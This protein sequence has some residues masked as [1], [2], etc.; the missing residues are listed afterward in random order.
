MERAMG[1]DLS[2]FSMQELFRL[3]AEGTTQSMTA[4]LLT[5][6]REPARQD[7]LEDCMRAAHSLKGAGRIV[8]LL[9]AVTIAH[10]ME[11]L[12]VL[13][14]K[15]QVA[16]DQP[17]IDQLLGGIDLIQALACAP[18]G[19]S[20]SEEAA[21]AADAERFAGDLARG[22]VAGG[23]PARRDAPEIHPE[24]RPEPHPETRPE[25]APL[26]AQDGGDASLRVSADTLNRMLDLA[27]ETLVESH[28]LRPFEEALLRIKRLQRAAA[29]SLEALE[30]ALPP[31]LDERARLALSQAREQVFACRQQLAQQ[32][33]SLETQNHRAG[34]LA[35]RLYNQALTVRMRPFADGLGA[36]PRMVRDIARDLGKQVAFD[37]T[38]ERTQIDRDILEKL[39]APLMHLLRNALDHGLESPEERLAAGKDAQGVIRLS[40][41]HHAGALQI[42][43]ADD[44][45]GIDPEVIRA[46]VVARGLS[47]PDTAERL[48]ESELFEFLFLP[49]FSMKDTVTHLSGRGVG[50]DVVQD[51][52]RQVRGLVRVTSRAGEGTQFKL[53][54][55]LTL[56][57]V[58]ALLVEI[59]GEPY[60]FPFAHIARAVRVPMEE[61]HR[62]EGRQYIT[63]DGQNIGLVGAD[64][65]FGCAPPPAGEG[66]SVVLLGGAAGL[67][68][69]V[70]DGFS[71]GAELVVRPLDPRL[72]KIRDI[73]AAALTEDGA[74]L[75]IVDVDDMVRSLEKLSAS[76]RLGPVGQEGARGPAQRR[77]RVLV[78]DDSFTVRELERKL[79]D[80]HGY[81]V[82]VA[83][84]G[85]DGWNALRE[86]PFDL[87]ISDIDMPRMDGIELVR[88]IRADPGLKAMPVMIL[89]YKDR[90]ED[91]QRG[92]EVGA[93]YYLTKG[94]FQN[95]ALIEAV[96]DLIGEPVS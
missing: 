90:E 88:R 73:A 5:L 63:V 70:V 83:V 16:L 1:Q 92:L 74:P 55:P 7:L 8:G 66:L 94:S 80:S 54:L 35:H 68:G 53:E 43:V 42:V 61:V 64:Q 24:T 76:D 67:H 44:G 40:A 71:G 12:F 45:R 82:E 9:P 10:A 36:L 86:R 6:E 50:L 19:Q 15:G 48:S 28:R 25:P 18:E 4:A 49:G 91:R 13:A 2:G 11:D 56:S 58:R 59:G 89:S 60:A 37:I 22:P 72:G 32:L 34:N 33:D 14:Q 62:L 78:V 20:P 57:V 81:Q 38:G 75:L 27:G 87:V 31:D 84:D 79:L 41:S 29:L 30:A 3:E 46:A 39:E 93:D 96:I 51:M 52:I 95:N 26:L 23:V 17:R 69:L 21:W 47:A 77:Q 65:L 85:M